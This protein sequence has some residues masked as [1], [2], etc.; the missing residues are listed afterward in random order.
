MK[1]IIII[2]II[3][4]LFYFIIIIIIII[5]IFSSVVFVIGM[6]LHYRHIHNKKNFHLSSHCIIFLDVQCLNSHHDESALTF[7][8]LSLMDGWSFLSGD[9]C[10]FKRFWIFNYIVRT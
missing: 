3:L 6:N 5:V 4:L 9:S 1:N 7:C 8:I 10:N 2:I